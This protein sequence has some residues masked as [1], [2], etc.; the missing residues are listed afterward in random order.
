MIGETFVGKTCIL[1]RFTEN[2]FNDDFLT[3]VGVDFRVKHVT[4]DD[5]TVGI[6][7]WDTAGQEQFHTITKSYFRG[8]HGILLCF[9]VT[10]RQSFDRIHMWMDSIHEAASETVAIVLVGNKNDMND[11]VVTYGQGLALAEEYSVPYF[12]TSAK[13]GQNIQ[14]VFEALARIVISKKSVDSPRRPRQIR[15]TETYG[16]T[17]KKCC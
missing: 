12:E 6:Q 8:A 17:E 15:V 16:E 4:I 1:V 14:E 3:T 13:T 10:S 5:K 11:R 7:I 9:D 2:S